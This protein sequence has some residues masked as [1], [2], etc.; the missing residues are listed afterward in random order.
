[1]GNDFGIRL[2]GHRVTLCDQ[3]IP[4]GLE[5]LDDAV[6]DNR[7]PV[8]RV[9]MGVIRGRC[10]V[11]RPPCVRDADGPRQRLIVE[12]RFQIGKLAFSA[13]AVNAALDQRRNPRGIIA[14]IFQPLQPVEQ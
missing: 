12:Q 6:V 4:K 2:R 7:H 11:S 1:M 5:I 14:A 13:T 9:R 10:A 3:L 8:R